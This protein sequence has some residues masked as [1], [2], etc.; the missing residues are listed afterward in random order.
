MTSQATASSTQSAPLHAASAAQVGQELGLKDPRTVTAQA[1]ASEDLEK[2]ADTLAKLLT[3]F[4]P[5]DLKSREDSKGSVETLGLDLQRDAARQ[6]ELLKEPIRKLSQRGADGGEVSN[7]LLELKMKVEELDP[8]KFN[9]E[10]GWFSRMVGSL[11]GV[12]SPLKKYFSQYESAQT[13]IAAIIQSLEKGRDQ[14][15]RDNFTLQEDQ[16]R[17]REMTFKLERAIQLAQLL[18][19]KLAYRLEREVEP[20]SDKAKFIAEELLFPLRQRILDLQQQMAVNQQGVL[21]IELILR[22]NKELVRGVNRA[23]NV[24]VSAL[25][26]AV[27]VAMALANQKIVLDK[28]SAINTTT[29]NLINSTAQQ[30]RTQGVEIQKQAASAMLDI[31]TLKQAF[32]TIN[33]AMDEIGKFKTEA[34]P[35]MAKS[36]GELDQLTAEAKKT[37]DKMEKGNQTR[38]E[39]QI[40]V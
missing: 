5:E 22:N 29:N 14:L 25:E 27:T 18:D 12:G 38:P 35:S 2:Q 15:G 19:Q 17:M 20:G 26:V 7:A 24:T 34:L 40:K 3:E 33:Q 23:L 32:T 13:V 11:P 16:K 1:G 37:I 4:K 21:A 6:S 36:I 8:A 10:A 30:L 31:N 28:V 9:F 39:L